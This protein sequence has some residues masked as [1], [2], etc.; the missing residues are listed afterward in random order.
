MDLV[1][2]GDNAVVIA[3]ATRKLVGHERIK[4][5]II[6]TGG[7]VAFR[8]LLML[9]AMQLLALPLVKIIGG[10][11]LFVI[12]FNLV[13]KGSTTDD[14]AENVKSSTTLLSAVGTII[15]ADFVMSLDNI[16][17]IAGAAD[18]RPIL[19]VFGL[20]ISIPIVVSASQII[21]AIMNRFPLIVWIGGLLIVYTAGTMI[22][23]DRIAQHLLN[24]FG[25]SIA[26]TPIVPI[27]CCVLLVMLTLIYNHF[28]LV[29]NH[30]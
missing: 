2:S 29:R 20:A 1:L 30:D 26:N 24:G 5:I 21:A 8:I 25:V 10:L 18:G 3:M 13:K 19:A 9:I 23:S 27:A 16:L 14:D 4:A 15:A 28:W 7:A 17:A 6:G 22:A 12:A 11:L